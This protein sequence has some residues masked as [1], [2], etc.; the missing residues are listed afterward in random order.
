MDLQKAKKIVSAYG[1]FIERARWRLNAIF[2]YNIPESLLSYSVECTKEACNIVAKHSYENG[3]KESVEDIERC[4]CWLGEFKDNEEAM[5]G[6]L[7]KFK[8]KKWYDLSIELTKSC[9]NVDKE[10]ISK[11]FKDVPFEKVDFDNLDFYSASKAVEI[12]ATYLKYGHMPLSYIFYQEIPE[13]FLPFP[14]EDL[15]KALTFYTNMSELTDNKEN[16]DTYTYGKTILE[17]E[18]IDDEVAMSQLI[19]NL[20]DKEI[21]NSIISDLKNFQQ[22]QA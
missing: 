8:I 16:A 2:F 21:R 13:S 17:K 3:N 10:Y 9:R 5:L 4:M 22:K 11:F 19:K 20:S 7:E 12:Y 15:I 18:Y 14:K 6:A 1:G